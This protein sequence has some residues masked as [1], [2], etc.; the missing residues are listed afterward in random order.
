MI[1]IIFFLQGRMV[2]LAMFLL[3]LLLLLLS[4][5]LLLL[6]FYLFIFFLKGRHR[7]N[8]SSLHLFRTAS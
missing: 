3:L 2:S 7:L 8:V 4:L 1:V 6:F 5:L